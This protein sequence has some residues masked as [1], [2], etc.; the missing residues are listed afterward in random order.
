M[1]LSRSKIIISIYCGLTL[2]MFVFFFLSLSVGRFHIPFITTLKII[3]SRIIEIERDWSDIQGSIILNIRFPRVA[4]AMVGGAGLSVCGTVFQGIFRNPLVSPGVVG[5]TAGSAF[6]AAL[7]ILLFD[8]GLMTQAFAFLFGAGAL[9]LTYSIT[10]KTRGNSFLVFILAGVVVNMFFQAMI[11]IIKFTADAE[12]KLPSIVYWLMGSLANATMEHV[13]MV[14]PLVITCT[15]ILIALKWR[16][17]VLSLGEEAAKSLGVNPGKLIGLI[18]VVSTLIVSAIVSVAGIVGWVGLI[19]PHIARMVVGSDHEVL[20]PVSA[21]MGSIFFLVIDDL[22]RT[23]SPMDIP[24][25]ILTAL[26]GAPFFIYLLIKT[27]GE[28]TL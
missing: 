22:A 3:F 16:I 27:K 17:N 12:E 1:S 20:L 19:I 9:G 7:A 24:L 10:K 6:G 11:S 26:T 13:L 2:V 14:V 21:L 4:I 15:I 8:W 18:L 25:G 5:V 28:W 23:I